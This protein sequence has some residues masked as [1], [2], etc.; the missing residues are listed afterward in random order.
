MAIDIR[1]IAPRP[2]YQA[3]ISG[4]CGNLTLFGGDGEYAN[5]EEF[6]DYVLNDWGW[7]DPIALYEVTL[8]EGAIRDISGDFIDWLDANGTIDH[9]N[10]HSGAPRWFFDFIKA[11]NVFYR[12]AA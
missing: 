9:F 3:L 10:E 7:E 6:F 1:A 11:H 12:R 8:D 4:P 2:L 5:A